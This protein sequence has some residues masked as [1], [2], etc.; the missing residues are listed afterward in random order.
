MRINPFKAPPPHLPIKNVHF[1]IL[2][3]PLSY[4]ITTVTQQC[5]TLSYRQHSAFQS[6]YCLPVKISVKGNSLLFSS[7]IT[8]FAVHIIQEG[9]ERSNDSPFYSINK[10]YYMYVHLIEI[11]VLATLQLPVIFSLFYFPI[12]TFIAEKILVIL[13]IIQI[14]TLLIGKNFLYY[15]LWFTRYLLCYPPHN[16]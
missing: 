6:V 12:K 7:S 1:S 2:N 3:S 13:Q 16:S 9:E 4:V 15:F 8:R 14:V 5:I 10:V 11:A